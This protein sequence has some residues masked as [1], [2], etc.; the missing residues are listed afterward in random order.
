MKRELTPQEKA[1][2]R[3][4]RMEFMTVFINGKQKRVR[5]P[6]TID[7]IDE[8]TFIRQSADPIWLVQ[9]G[10]YVYLENE[11]FDNEPDVAATIGGCCEALDAPS[12]IPR[13]QG[14]GCTVAG[15]F[16]GAGRFAR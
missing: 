14:T 3:R 5:R 1:A 8:D 15:G 7:G 11:N 13:F 9:H 12:P 2:K 10:M 4:R 6:V 16:A